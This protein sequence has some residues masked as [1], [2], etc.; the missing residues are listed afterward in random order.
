MVYQYHIRLLLHFR[1]KEAMNLP[2]YLFRS[3]GKMSNR[4]KA[5]SKKVDTIVFHSG[6]IKMLVME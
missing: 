3:I 6:H 4:V 5:K 2:S 1:E